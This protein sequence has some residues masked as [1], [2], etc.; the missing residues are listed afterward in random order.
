MLSVFFLDNDYFLNNNAMNYRH[1]TYLPGATWIVLLALAVLFLPWLGETF[2]S[3]KGEPREAIVAMSMLQSGEWVLPVSYGTD[4]PFKPPFMAWLIAGLA[5]L[6]NGGVV[7]EY[8]SRLPSA[9]AVIFMVMMGYR[10][11]VRN[12]GTRFGMIFAFVLATSFEVFRSGIICRLDMV[13]TACMV[14]GM[15]LLFDIGRETERISHT[16]WLRYLAVIAL[17][18]CATLT[19]GPIGVLLPCLAVGIYWLLSGKRFFTTLGILVL[20]AL[21]SMVLPALW[22][23]EAY[24][25]GGEDFYALMYEENIG[26]LTGTMS[27]E[28]HEN[29]IWYNFM[30]LAYGMLPWML[31]M[32]MSL[33]CIGKASRRPL[34]P[35]GMFALV[36]A[37]VVVGFYC[38]P[39]SKRSVY[40]L[41]AYPFICYGITSVIDSV[42]TIKVNRV[43]AW[44]M[45]IIAVLAPL[46]LAA[47]QIWPV[48]GVVV[49]TIPWW[50]YIILAI[51]VSTGIAWFVNRHSPVGH[52]LV[53]VWAIYL[54][55][56][57]V[58]QPAILNP[59]SDMSLVE[60]LHAMPDNTPMLSI[61]SWP[62]PRMYS[63]NYYMNDRLRG[64]ESL[65]K[66]ADYPAGTVIFVTHKAD[67]TGLSKNFSFHPALKRECD[68]R[69]PL[70]I[71]IRK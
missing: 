27:Y 6:F 34:K 35:A 19:K 42:E 38:I 31:L 47:M 45:A 9:L 2:Y 17:F 39:A 30:T 52:S 10:W 33:V 12:R 41:P 22:Y 54:A 66:A 24:L 51:T 21:L 3:S 29:P 69:K 18:T 53:I 16:R 46:A 36:A 55:Y 59:R 43:F 32:L 1:D 56:A 70:G 67:T 50:H 20:V 40:L 62:Y 61:D 48:K 4:L 60:K 37:V 58:A 15:L 7:N 23:Y 5:W 8:L 28:S 25:R 44:I 49:D 65:E 71:A 13:L 14:S 26:R 64:V 68:F 63:I 11:A 57:A